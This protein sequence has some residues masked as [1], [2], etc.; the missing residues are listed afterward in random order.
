MC[1]TWLSFHLELIRLLI[2]L[3][4]VGLLLFTSCAM[5][6]DISGNWNMHRSVMFSAPSTC[7]QICT[8]CREHPPTQVGHNDDLQSGQNFNEDNELA[9]EHL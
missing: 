5:L 2:E 7:V 6:L 8:F 3:G 4:N 1:V 9:D